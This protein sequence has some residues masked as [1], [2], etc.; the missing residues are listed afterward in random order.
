MAWKNCLTLCAFL[1]DRQ[2]GSKHLKVFNSKWDNDLVFIKGRDPGDRLRCA[3]FPVKLASPHSQILSA[4]EQLLAGCDF[5]NSYTNCENRQSLKSLTLITM[6]LLYGEGLLM[7]TVSF[8][9]YQ[10]PGNRLQ[11]AGNK[12]Y[13]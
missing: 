8:F 11:K 1:C 6:V 7:N 2:C 9:N 5:N 10:T 4:P 12:K 13:P 3:Q